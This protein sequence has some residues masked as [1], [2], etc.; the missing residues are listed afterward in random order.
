MKDT[1]E[2][3]LREQELLFEMEFQSKKDSP[4]PE[5]DYDYVSDSDDED[6]HLW[7]DAQTPDLPRKPMPSWPEVKAQLNHWGQ[8]FSSGDTGERAIAS[9][10]IFNL[11]DQ[12]TESSKDFDDSDKLKKWY[13]HAMGIVRINFKGEAGPPI[14]YLKDYY[15]ED[16]F[17]N[18]ILHTLGF[19]ESDS[20]S[21]TYDATKGAQYVT[22]FTNTLQNFSKQRRAELNYDF[23]GK[24]RVFS[25]YTT[26]AEIQEQEN[27]PESQAI[28]VEE[29]RR[30]AAALVDLAK[31]TTDAMQLNKVMLPIGDNTENKRN[32]VK[33]TTLQ[34]FY[35]FSLVNFTRYA[36]AP[37][38][39]R[40]DRI[41]MSTADMGF[42]TFSTKM[43]EP[44]YWSL[45]QAELSDY[46]LE[47]RL[48]DETD[49]VKELQQEAAAHYCG[50]KKSAIS[51]KFDAARRYLKCHWHFKPM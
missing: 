24:N 32:G 4:Q 38:S 8:V 17:Y 12:V 25:V 47:N 49:G 23:D 29:N 28:Q 48:Y 35:S 30:Q 34:L 2:L 19:S 37:V 27:I 21:G 3:S 31:L 39:H 9:E 50:I 14:R 11:F 6:A 1:D 40:D 44:A 13:D 5:D 15:P 7:D 18:A 20:N 36:T 10:H 26:E 22:H 46:V 45:V 16:L 33:A 43:K 42:L 51:L 41:L